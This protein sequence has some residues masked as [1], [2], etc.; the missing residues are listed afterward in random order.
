MSRHPAEF[1]DWPTN[2]EIP[3]GPYRAIVRHHV[4][5]DTYD[6]FIDLGWNDYRYHSVRLL[7]AD[8]PETN[9]AASKAAGLAAKAF[10]QE[11]MPVGARVLLYTAPDPDN[12]GRY[13]ARITLEDGRDLTDLLINAG[14]AVPYRG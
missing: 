2:L 1:D 14:H 12:F 6:L 8:T 13:L 3:Y 4:D 10:V 7:G 11:Q 5:G 9:R